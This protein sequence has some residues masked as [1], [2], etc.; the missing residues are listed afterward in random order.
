MAGD[1]PE[2]PLEAGP[3]DA[4]E[5]NEP[6]DDTPDAAATREKLNQALI[7]VCSFALAVTASRMYATLVGNKHVDPCSSFVFLYV[8]VSFDGLPVGQYVA[9][10][11]A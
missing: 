6:T 7:Q 3:S 9:S 11:V 1:D 8:G 4:N 5:L 10:M 2:Q